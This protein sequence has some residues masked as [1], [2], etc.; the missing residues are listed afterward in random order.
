[1]IKFLQGSVI[2][3]IIVS[4]LSTA[5]AAF[6]ETDIFVVVYKHEIVHHQHN[7]SPDRR[8]RRERLTFCLQNRPIGIAAIQG[9]NQQ[10]GDGASDE[11]I[12]E[13]KEQGYNVLSSDECVYDLTGGIHVRP[14][15]STAL[16]ILIGAGS[17]RRDG[18]KVFVDVG[19][20]RH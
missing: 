19:Y 18:P 1:M 3:V 14:Q 11:V 13:L 12:A 4:W 16:S 10:V 5:S 7:D 2:Y 6:D 17:I 9:T 15:S 20:W 8:K